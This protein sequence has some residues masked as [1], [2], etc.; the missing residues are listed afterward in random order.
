MEGGEWR[1][2]GAECRVQS[3]EWG[4]GSGEKEVESGEWRV[5]S[6]EC[7]ARCINFVKQRA[8]GGSVCLSSCV[9]SMQ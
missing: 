5:E 3:G 4:V 7:R 8:G 1:V 9:A 2:D 6:A